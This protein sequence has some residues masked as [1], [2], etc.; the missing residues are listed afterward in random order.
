MGT[1][2]TLAPSQISKTF[3]NS[4]LLHDSPHPGETPAGY[5]ARLTARF[6]VDAPLEHRRELAQFFT[7][8]EIAR[9]MATLARPTRSVRRLLDPGAGTGIL[10]CALCEMLPVRSGPVHLD[11]YEVDPTL[12][13][14]CETTLG[15]AK[16]WLKERGISFTFQ[17]KRTDYVLGNA[18]RLRPGL[19]DGAAPL[20][21]DIAIANPPYFKL[22]KLDPRAVTAS[23]IVHG[24]PNIYAL[25]MAIT[26][27]LLSK[28]GTMV[29]I[30]PRSFTTGPYFQR[31]RQYLFTAVVPETVHLFHSRKDAFRRD[32][33]LQE[34]VILRARKTP[35]FQSATV[36]VSSSSGIGDL[37]QRKIRKVPLRSVIDLGLRNFVFNIPTDETDDAVVHFVRSWSSTL[38]R[39]GL[40]VSTGPVVAFRARDFLLHEVN[41]S[42]HAVPLIW[43]QHVRPMAVQWPIAGF[44]KP[45]YLR[46][47]SDKTLLIPNATYVLLRRF[48]AKEE[49][50]RL[51]AAPLFRSELPGQTIGLENHLNYIHRPYGKLGDDEAVGLAAIL[52]S[53]LLDRYFRVSNGNTQVNA[54]EIRSIPLPPLRFLAMV[55]AEIKRQSLKPSEVEMA[56]MEVLHIPRAL[57]KMMQANG[58]ESSRKSPGN[59]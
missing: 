20:G 11:A 36:T 56:V 37:Q 7:P 13:S 33:V 59:S 24:Q 46:G 53:A 4:F 44:R 41:G 51:T 23:A 49:H 50:R 32:D 14:L 35:P 18:V 47:D 42:K 16:Q 52:G 17:V 30:T 19:F 26:A 54:A 9:F 40:E 31:F 25:F 12:S 28:G 38:H 48:T 57:L 2:E 6:L 34:N 21:Y 58:N 10:A 39:L 55:G 22:S 15:Y 27:S 29:T 8:V 5:A 45:Q 1:I 43:L 3:R